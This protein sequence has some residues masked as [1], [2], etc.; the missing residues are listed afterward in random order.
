MLL[1]LP[2]PWSILFAIGV[3]LLAAAAILTLKGHPHPPRKSATPSQRKARLPEIQPAGSEQSP[4]PTSPVSDKKST[5]SQAGG[6]QLSQALQRRL[7][8][9]VSLRKHIPAMPGMVSMVHP[10]T[11]LADVETWVRRTKAI[12]RPTPQLLAEF[13]YKP[14]RALLDHLLV[15]NSLEPAYK[16]ELDRRIA[17]LGEIITQ[18][19]DQDR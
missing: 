16:K 7:D 12:L 5:S 18:L 13:N 11:T 2:S 17:N 3:F 1:H 4:R 10:T 19:R 6:S 9:G 14:P 15:T 8:Q